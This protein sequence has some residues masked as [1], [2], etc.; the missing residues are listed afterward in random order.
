VDNLDAQTAQELGVPPNTKGVVVTDV[1][2]SSPY[3]DSG[4]HRGDV[5][6]EVNRQPVKDVADFEKAMRQGGKEP[7]LLVNR[8][9]G[10][11][12]LAA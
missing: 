12:Y 10:T 6:Q 3:A 8:H 11:M 4:L 7:L 9:G 1:S 2:P 5:I